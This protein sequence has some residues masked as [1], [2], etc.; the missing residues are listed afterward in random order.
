MNDQ[1]R[2]I[3][4]VFGHVGRLLHSLAFAKGLNP[5]QW[6]ALRYLSTA[7]DSA[8]SVTSFARHHQTTKPAASKTID[9]LLRK[10]LVRKVAV[11]GDRRAQRVDLTP[12]AIR[13]LAEDPLNMFVGALAALDREQTSALAHALQVIVG[14]LYS[15]IGNEP[16]RRRK[17]SAR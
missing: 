5:A 13:R 7:N 4:E 16:K 2:A 12:K 3:A 10:G 17:E 6:S 9:A 11:P 15:Q 14:G 1:N 8:R